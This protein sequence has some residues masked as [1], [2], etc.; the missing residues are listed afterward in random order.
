MKENNLK[1]LSM[2][3]DKEITISSDSRVLADRGDCCFQGHGCQEELKSLQ[4][5]EVRRILTKLIIHLVIQCHSGKFC[6]LVTRV[7]WVGNL[8][9]V[10]RILVTR[11]P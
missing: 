1:K 6:V 11:G 8:V 5:Q 10:F 4:F 7:M 9:G 2:S 3:S